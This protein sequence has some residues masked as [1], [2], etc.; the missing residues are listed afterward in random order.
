MEMI[1]IVS[2]R[3]DIARFGMEAFAPRHAKPT[4]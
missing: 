2:S 1:A 3:Y 4:C